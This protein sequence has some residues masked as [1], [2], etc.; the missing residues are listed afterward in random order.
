MADTHTPTE[1]RLRDA[2]QQIADA[3]S[4][5]SYS[6]WFLRQIALEALREGAP[7]STLPPKR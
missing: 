6:A 5:E 1:R 4:T 2:L 7:P 3:L